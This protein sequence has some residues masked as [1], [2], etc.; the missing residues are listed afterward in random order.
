MF[1]IE[2][3]HHLVVQCPFYQEDRDAIYEDLYC[4][5]K[6]RASISAESPSCVYTIGYQE[7]EL[8]G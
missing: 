1:V 6:R 8:M 3:L 2:D 7:S 4:S 5:V